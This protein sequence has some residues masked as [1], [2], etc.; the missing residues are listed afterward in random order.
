MTATNWTKTA[1]IATAYQ[2]YPILPGIYYLLTETGGKILQETGDG[3]FL[4]NFAS[5]GLVWTKQ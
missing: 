2:K 5:T 1:T 4:E 3:I